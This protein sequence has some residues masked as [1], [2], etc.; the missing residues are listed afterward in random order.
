MCTTT[1]DRSK[2][3]PPE[4][5][6]VPPPGTAGTS[7][8]L[9]PFAAVPYPSLDLSV[10]DA[11]L[12]AALTGAIAAV[13]NALGPTQKVAF[14]ILCFATNG[15]HRYAGVDDNT[16]HYSGSLLKVA[17]MYPAHEL[18]AAANRLA[19]KEGPHRASVDAFFKALEDTFDGQIKTTAVPEALAAAEALAAKKTP[20]R[21]TPSYRQ[22][23]EVTGTGGA[24]PP[25]VDFTADFTTQMTKMIE[26]SDNHAAGECV[27]RLS[28]TY[29][30]AALIKAGFFV[31]GTMNGIWFAGDYTST[32]ASPS[33]VARVNSENDKLAAQVTTTK[34][35]M[36]VFALIHLNKLV[37]QDGNNARMRALLAKA[38]NLGG[39]FHF[40]PLSPPANQPFDLIQSK[41][42]R[43]P[44]KK[45]GETFSEGQLLRWTSPTT[46]TPASKG[47]T[48]FFAVCWQ[49]L[50]LDKIGGVVDVCAKTYAKLLS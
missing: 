31:P 41:I 38:A 3:Q 47:L 1:H 14:S 48:G 23:F 5:A 15:H 10:T 50:Q 32:D 49:N 33:P 17:A 35:M 22:I 25:S 20:F 29:I 34:E 8:P 12:K 11:P 13:G 21:S 44:L 7:Q 45:G 2:S 16:M 9:T 40:A 43:G 6:D 30:N 19:R 27:R 37:T 4:A 42:G 46:A 36:R 39:W 26:V 18:L 28:Y 24:N